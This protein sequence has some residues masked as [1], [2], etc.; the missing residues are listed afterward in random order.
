MV[1]V[2]LPQSLT[3]LFPGCPRQVELEAAT[4]KGVID[5]LNQ[6]WPGMRN[7]LLDVGPALRQHILVSIDGQVAGLADPVRAGAVVRI[8]PSI[9]GG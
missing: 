9:T 1:K 6:R 7:R 2:L 4:V 5:E 8:I 3:A